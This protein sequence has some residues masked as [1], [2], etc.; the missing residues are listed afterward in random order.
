MRDTTHGIEHRLAAAKLAQQALN[1][2][3]KLLPRT[4]LEVELRQMQRLLAG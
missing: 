2:D 4:K 1:D 3:L